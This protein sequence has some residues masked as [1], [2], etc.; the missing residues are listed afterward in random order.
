M[1]PST[2]AWM[3][4]IWN[5]PRGSSMATFSRSLLK[6]SLPRTLEGFFRRPSQ[7]WSRVLKRGC[8][9]SAA[10]TAQ[11]PQTQLNGH[12]EGAAAVAPSD[13]CQASRDPTTCKSTAL[14]LNKRPWTKVSRRS[15]VIALKLGMTQLWKK[16][17]MPMAVT[18]LQVRGRCR[19]G[20]VEQR[21]W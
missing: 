19:V 9:S 4:F 7:L 3:C 12:P 14:V 16:D 17:G 2:Q 1:L 21:Q 13:S 11:S 8:L 18:V 6:L 15:G 5:H 10:N 20:L